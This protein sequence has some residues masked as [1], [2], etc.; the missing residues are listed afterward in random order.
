MKLATAYM[1]F[2]V[3]CC[4]VHA[5]T[6]CSMQIESN[7]E[8]CWC[9]C[10]H[11]LIAAKCEFNTCYA[12]ASTYISNSSR[13]NSSSPSSYMGGGRSAAAAASFLPLPV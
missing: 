2:S 10:C 11:M 5:L 6:C 8:V 3:T 12:G 1:L 9:R 4:G 13:L 7:L